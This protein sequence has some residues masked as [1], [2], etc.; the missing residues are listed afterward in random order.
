MTEILKIENADGSSLEIE[1]QTAPEQVVVWVWGHDVG[2][3]FD[4]DQEE[5]LMV[6]VALLDALKTVWPVYGELEDIVTTLMEDIDNEDTS[7]EDS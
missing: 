5:T 6:A 3:F 4:L 1:T 7:D 2:L